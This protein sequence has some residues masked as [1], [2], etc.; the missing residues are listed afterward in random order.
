MTNGTTRT[1]SVTDLPTP[2]GDRYFEDY[3]P[4]EVYEFGYVTVTEEEIIEF[5]ER[6]DPQPIHIDREY[7]ATGPFGGIIA[8]GWHTSAVCMR[9]IAD[10][11][12]SKVASLA[13]PGIDELRWPTP[14]RPGDAVRLRTTIIEARPSASKPDRGVVITGCELIT[15]DDDRTVLTFRAINLIRRRQAG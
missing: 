10:H 2:S 9:L 15:K 3:R 6:F 14:L 11:Y 8:S 4:G 1:L 5:A 13:S 12:L 7:A